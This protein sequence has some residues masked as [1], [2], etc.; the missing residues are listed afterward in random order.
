MAKR[1]AVVDPAVS[2]AKFEREIADYRRLQDDHIRRGWLMVKSE[3]PDV[4]VVFGTPQL[5]PPAIVFGALIDFSDYDFYPPSVTLV[6]PFSQVAYK[7]KDA[8]S[9]L[10]RIVPTQLPPGMAAMMGA[11]ADAQLQQE[12]PLLVAFGPDDIPFVCVKGTRE[13]HEN[14]GHTADSWFTYRRTGNEG[15]LYYL[16][17]ILY[18]YG[19][20]PISD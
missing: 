8:P 15:T 7:A 2:R 3:W 12:Q 11:G 20:S 13:Y 16:L 6:H 14:P 4:F 19:S 5:N 9:A 18:Q 1:A 17:N 10:K